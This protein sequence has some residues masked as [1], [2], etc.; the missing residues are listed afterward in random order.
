MKSIV[1]YSSLTG[2]QIEHDDEN[3]DFQAILEEKEQKNII[4]AA[5]GELNKGQQEVF[6][7]YYIF[8][9]SYADIS[10]DLG[11]SKAAVA[12]RIHKGK[13]K[14]KNIL[15]PQ[16]TDY[17]G[18]YKMDEKTFVGKIIEGIQ[19][20]S[21]PETQQG[22]GYVACFA[23]LYIA[24][25][26]DTPLDRMAVYNKFTPV[27]GID[28]LTFDHTM[29]TTARYV[30]SEELAKEYGMDDYVAYTMGYAGFNY[31]RLRKGEHDKKYVFSHI[32][33]SLQKDI[34]V[35]METKNGWCV[36]T[37]YDENGFIYGSDKTNEGKD[38]RLSSDTL[39][40]W[41]DLF[42][43]ENWYDV[44]DSVAIF[45]NKQEPTITKKDIF[46]RLGRIVDDME[47]R[48][49][50]EKL[51]EHLS[52]S[53]FDSLTIDEKK[54][55]FIQTLNY[56]YFHVTRRAMMCWS[57]SDLFFPDYTERD[58]NLRQCING[59]MGNSHDYCW[60]AFRTLGK[61]GYHVDMSDFPNFLIS[62]KRHKV[63][64]SVYYVK[65]N[66]HKTGCVCK[67]IAGD[68]ISDIER[69]LTEPHFDIPRDQVGPDMG[70][71]SVEEIVLEDSVMTGRYVPVN[72][73][74]I[75]NDGD[76]FILDCTVDQG[77]YYYDKSVFVG[78]ETAHSTGDNICEKIG[79]TYLKIYGNI[80]ISI[81]N[82]VDSWYDN[83]GIVIDPDRK[84]MIKVGTNHQ[85]ETFVP[86]ISK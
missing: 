57:M 7:L 54:L 74:N 69:H 48:G 76:I 12:S 30:E 4:N 38:H 21:Q 70:P 8:G 23:S 11:I 32:I 49:Y 44:M 51:L 53:Y 28:M 26:R 79:G 80:P 47:K 10:V 15:L 17:L 6:L 81:Y 75:K 52:D 64:E 62:E 61:G 18:G 43:L 59:Y 82:I 13:K 27:A 71:F 85:L 16:L 9:K 58:M 84:M 31:E 20:P 33:A 72:E 63:I 39:E 14:L 73:C 50:D 68:Y 34:P 46:S 41:N 55:L 56:L 67:I 29:T 25:E 19:N 65:E 24:V 5:I 42:V 60:N 37:G 83:N 35:L 3:D 77:M 2:L 22:D 40:Y 86:T 36:V 1:V 45:M 78:A 66:D